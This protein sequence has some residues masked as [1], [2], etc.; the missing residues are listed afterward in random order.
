VYGCFFIKTF[1]GLRKVERHWRTG[2]PASLSV[3][4]DK[5]QPCDVVDRPVELARNE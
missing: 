5:G 2:W 1:Y 3:E 4:R